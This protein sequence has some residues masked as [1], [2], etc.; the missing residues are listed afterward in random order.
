LDAGWLGLV[1]GLLLLAG[2]GTLAYDGTRKRRD[3][4]PYSFPDAATNALD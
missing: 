3:N 1:G 2:V 4:N